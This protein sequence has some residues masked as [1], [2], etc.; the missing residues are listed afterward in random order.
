[1]SEATKSAAFFSPKDDSR[2]EFRTMYIHLQKRLLEV[3]YDIF[4]AKSQN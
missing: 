1:M 3:P 2:A 4:Y